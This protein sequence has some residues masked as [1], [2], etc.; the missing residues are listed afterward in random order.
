[1][2]SKRDKEDG[3]EIIAYLLETR[4]LEKFESNNSQ[5]EGN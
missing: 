4:R 3:N 1:V 2:I 5:K